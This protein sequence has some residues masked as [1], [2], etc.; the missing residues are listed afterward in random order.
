MYK[1]YIILILISFYLNAG[2]I[3]KIVLNGNKITQNTIILETLNHQIGDTINI[4]LAQQDLQ[5]L[6]NLGPFED[7][8]IHPADSIY[9][10]YLFEYPKI[11]YSPILDKDDVKGTSA[12]L[13]TRFNNIN[14]KNKKILFDIQ[15]GKKTIFN[16]NYL[17]PKHHYN[18]DTLRVSLKNE[19]FE[20][21]ETDYSLNQFSFN[22][23]YL[24]PLKNNK[25]TLG[26]EFELSNNELKYL[27]NDTYSRFT[28]LSATIFF[29]R[30]NL[31]NINNNLTGNIFNIDY[32]LLLFSDFYPTLNKIT[33]KNKLYI[34]LSN[35]KNSGRLV[36]TN[37]GI[38]YFSNNIAIFNKTYIASENYVRGYS[39]E[40]SDN[41]I[42]IRNKLK[43]NNIITSSIQLEIPLY[44]NTESLFF[45]DY[46]LGTNDYLNWELENKIRSYGFG[47]R[48]E[49]KKLIGIDFCIGLNKF[50]HKEF[51]VIVNYKY[52]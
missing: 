37:Q 19:F 46:G 47:F 12:G 22:I 33:I 34:P 5:A 42:S 31:N 6:I 24:L 39:I 2:V 27:Y 26:S 49:I 25:N 4:N 51:H 40:P 11:I 28:E 16:L 7:A 41:P 30:N 45:F 14:G 21:I 43:W 38:C 50:S 20:N 10:I 32:T 23:N 44:K 17:D 8:I 52:Y 13:S 15:I 3:K 29:R 18:K 36:F 9:Y 1:H 35:I 48:Y